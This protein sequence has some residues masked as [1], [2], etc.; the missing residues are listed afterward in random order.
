LIGKARQYYGKSPEIQVVVPSASSH[1]VKQLNHRVKE[2]ENSGLKSALQP[3]ATGR[4]LP[5]R[6]W[7]FGD[8]TGRK[9]R[10]SRK[11]EENW[12]RKRKILRIFDEF[13]HFSGCFFR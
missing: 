9:S 12:P 10:N 2:M 13:R 3:A 4:R 1:I 6:E 8:E 11:T 5:G 7:F